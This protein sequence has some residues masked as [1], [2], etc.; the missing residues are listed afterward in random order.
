M[1]RQNR[2][3]WASAALVLGV[4]VVASVYV[5][6]LPLLEASAV[7]EVAPAAATP[8]APDTA[9]IVVK[10]QQLQVFGRPDAEPVK[11]VK[12]VKVSRQPLELTG[13]LASDA[14]TAQV[15]IRSGGGLESIYGIDSILPG[16]AILKTIQSDHV[17]IEYEGQLEK[18]PLERNE[19]SISQ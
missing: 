13:I 12:A 1:S 11:V 18:L 16:G 14:V 15:L 6:R 7:A 2:I 4:F 5:L 9:A 17:L 19:V 3:S 8:N 10:L